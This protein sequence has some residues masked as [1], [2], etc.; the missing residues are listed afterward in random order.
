[1][2]PLIRCQ[3]PAG[4]VNPCGVLGIEEIAQAS[5]AGMCCQVWH[6]RADVFEVPAV[7]APFEVAADWP[8]FEPSDDDVPGVGW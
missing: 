7:I 6:N 2:R 1:M 4:T 3:A 8:P 5:E